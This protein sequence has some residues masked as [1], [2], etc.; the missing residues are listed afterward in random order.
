M[1]RLVVED[2]TGVPGANSFA[3]LQEAAV[4][5]AERGGLIPVREVV[6]SEVSFAPAGFV[7]A[8]LGT[9]ALV[10]VQSLV[11]VRGAGEAENSGFG[12]VLASTEDGLV[13]DWLETVEEAAGAVVRVT[14]FEQ[15]GWWASTTARL[16]ASLVNSTSFML[17]RY[18]FA[19][20]ASVTGQALPWPRRFVFVDPGGVPQWGDLGVL[21]EGVGWLE[22]PYNVVPSGVKRCQLW[23]ALADLESPLNAPV[24]PQQFLVSKSIGP[25]GI[26][27]TFGGQVRLRRFPHADAEVA[28]LLAPTVSGGGPFHPIVRT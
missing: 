1:S 24:D 23:L 19:G 17:R 6:S 14:V 7:N 22:V 2:G 16:E 28:G 25:A 18:A 8:P 15:S 12:Y 5:H 11:E 4:F 3:G 9:F 13:I 27:K 10:P 21:P 20:V 26:V